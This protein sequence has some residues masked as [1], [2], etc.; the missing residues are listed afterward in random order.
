MSNKQKGYVKALKE[1]IR[2]FKAVEME[3][4]AEDDAARA[5]EEHRLEDEFAEICGIG[6][7][8]KQIILTMDIDHQKGLT[9]EQKRHLHEIQDEMRE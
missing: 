8:S 6:A 1:Q 2:T 9:D 5:K 7:S 3:N 4:F